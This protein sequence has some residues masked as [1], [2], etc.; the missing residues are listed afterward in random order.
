MAQKQ[1][2]P[3]YA[4]RRAAVLLLDAVAEGRLLPE[5]MPKILSRLEPE[6]RARAQRLALGALRNFDRCDRIL[7]PFLKKRPSDTVMSTLRL[8]TY[9]LCVEQAAAHGVVNS[10]VAVV[11]AGGKARH[12][13][14]LVNAVLRKVADSGPAAWDKL[15]EPR[16]PKWLRKVLLADFG[17]DI[18]AA[19]ESAHLAGAPL[20]LTAK[21]DGAELAN[22]LGGVLLPTGSV[23]L[24]DAAQVSALP[25]YDAGDW[26]VQD[27]A[28][29]LPARILNAQPGETVLDMCAAPGGKTMQLAAAGA[30]VTALDI[31]ERRLQRLS[32]NL[33]R[34]GLSATTVTADALEFEAPQFDA[35]LLDAPCTATGTIRR[36]PDLPQAKDGSDFPGLFEL[37]EY[38]IDRAWALLKPGGRMIY[39]TCS[40]LIDEGEEQLRDALTRHSDMRIERDALLVPGVDPAWVGEDGGLRLRPDF[41]AEHGGMDGFFITLFRK[42]G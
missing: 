31:S 37:Q 29:A 16:L 8:G 4:P 22:R 28:A 21:G 9:E 18:V 34:T 33:T 42:A 3:G 40:L 32:E 13:S 19:I 10:L 25:G 7:G 5:V 20:D 17:K 30:E 12:F 35:I 23:R 6:D 26:W 14:G 24:S 39:C 1:P 36:H 41:W 2:L 15:P 11:Q 27:A 38:M